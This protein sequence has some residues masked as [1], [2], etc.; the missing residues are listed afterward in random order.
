M[1]LSSIFYLVLSMTPPE[2]AETE[3]T[4]PEKTDTGNAQAKPNVIC[5][6][7]NRTSERLWLP[8]YARYTE[9]LREDALLS[10][11]ASVD[12][13]DRLDI[14]LT[15]YAHRRTSLLGCILR[16]RHFDQAVRAFLQTYPTAQIINV[17]A[18]LCTRF[19]RVDNGR[20]HWY[21]VDSPTV[22]HLRRQLMEPCDRHCSLSRNDGDLSWIEK[23]AGAKRRPTLVVMEGVSMYCSET[24]NQR[25]FQTLQDSFDTVQVLMDIIHPKFTVP[26]ASLECQLN[27]SVFQWGLETLAE[28][29]TWGDIRILDTR[30]YLSDLF[31]YPARLEP[32]MT[33]FP[34]ILTPLLKNSAR[35]VQLRI[36]KVAELKESI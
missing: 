26:F 7:V 30:D 32:W 36:G 23:I 12:W 20:L 4:E 29:E 5:S 11:P 25:L 19:W 28:L 14:E 21:D 8:L 10:D 24:L 16:S 3:K 35:I 18:G 31:D 2:T 17:G 34:G 1:P 13:V 15:S 9:T 33:H 6:G 27:D 22:T